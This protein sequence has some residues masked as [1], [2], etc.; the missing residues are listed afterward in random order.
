M[1]VV[2][3]LAPYQKGKDWLFEVRRGKTVFIYGTYQNIAGSR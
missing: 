2:D 1:Q 3:L